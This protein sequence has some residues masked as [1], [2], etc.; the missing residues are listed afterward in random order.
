MCCTR[1]LCEWELKDGAKGEDWARFCPGIGNP[2]CICI[3]YMYYVFCILSEN[4]M[5]EQRVETEEQGSVH[6][7]SILYLYFA[8]SILYFVIWVKIERWSK[9][10]RLGKVLPIGDPSYF[11]PILAYSNIILHQ[12]YF[13]P[14]WY[15]WRII[16]EILH[17]NIIEGWSED[18]A[19]KDGLPM[20][21][22]SILTSC[23][24]VHLVHHFV[25]HPPWLSLA[26][27]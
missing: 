14:I 26:E 15:Y 13:T 19:S 3:L 22:W 16:E 25:W 21:G 23:L 17:S 1:I 6:Q 4:W 8:L 9:G 24:P 10:W 20:G 2:I 5:M 7:R 11:I 27:N 12:F 18:W